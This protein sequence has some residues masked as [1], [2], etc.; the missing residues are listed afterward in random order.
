MLRI[1]S[2]VFFLISLNSLAQADTGAL[3]PS[4]FQNHPIFDYVHVDHVE[5]V[6]SDELIQEDLYKVTYLVEGECAPYGNGDACELVPYCEYI[7]VDVA[8]PQTSVLQ[9]FGT[10]ISC[11]KHIEDVIK[12]ILI[13]EL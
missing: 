6:F 11:D 1:L 9:L 8:L 3:K 13:D 5:K 4:D 7:W 12:P 10:N 2:S